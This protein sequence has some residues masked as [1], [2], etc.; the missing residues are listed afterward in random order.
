MEKID[1][2]NLPAI[3]P[4]SKGRNT[5]LRAM[6]LQL[7]VGEGLFLPRSEWKG[8]SR[9]AYIVARIKKTHGFL[10]FYLSYCEQA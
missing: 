5:L 6:L 10:L 9:P 8:K 1:K 4:V 2:A 3:L 7:Q